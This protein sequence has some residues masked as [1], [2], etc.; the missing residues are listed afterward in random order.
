MRLPFVARDLP[1]RIA[2]GAYVLHTGIEKWHGTAERAAG[3]HGIAAAAFPL[4]SKVPATTFLKLLAA[5]E[6]TTGA[7]LLAPVVPNRVAGAPL[8]AF[9]ATLLAMYLRTPAFH[10]PGS[11]WPTSAGIAVSKDVWMLGIGL[12]LLLDGGRRRPATPG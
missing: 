6:V 5:G 11:L 8:T 1:P 7:L 12:S 10:E 3:V 9:S 4:L 2:T